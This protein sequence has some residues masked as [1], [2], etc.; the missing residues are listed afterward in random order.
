[1]RTKLQ[2]G[3]FR[4]KPVEA[5]LAEGR[6]HRRDHFERQLRVAF[7]ESRCSAFGQA[8]DRDI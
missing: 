6:A 7:R 1:M 8:P 3:A 4:E 5:F 2:P